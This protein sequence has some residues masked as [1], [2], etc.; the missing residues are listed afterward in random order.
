MGVLRFKIFRDIWHQKGRTLQVMLIIGIGA[1]AIGMILTTRNLVVPGM[2]SGWQDFR[3]PMVRIFVDPPVPESMMDELAHIKN[4][5]EIEGMNNATIEWRLKPTD[6]WKQGGLTARADYNDMVMDKLTLVEGDWPHDETVLIGQGDDGFFGLPKHGDVYLRYDDKVYVLHVDGV[7]YNEFQQPASFGGTAQFYV[8]KEYYDKIIGNLDYGQLL[9]RADFP[10]DEKKVGE[11]AD[12]IQDRLE[13]SNR[14]SGRF[15]TDPNKHF[16]QDSM[17]G[18]FFLLGVL[19]VVALIMGL[20]LVYNTINSVIISQVDQIGVMKAV[21]ARTS[22]IVRFFLLVVTIYGLLALFCSM[23]MTI[24]G[25]WQIS[26]WLI[27]SFGADPGSFQVDRQAVLV[28]CLIALIAP[29]LAALVP[30]WSASRTTVREAISTYGLG[31][32]SGL[33]EKLLAR[34]RYISRLFIVTVTNT[35]RHKGRVTLLQIALVISGLV[36]MTVI[37]VRDSVVY[38]VK[39][40][41]FSILNA[42]VTLAFEDPQRIA[43]IEAL[44]LAYPGVKSVEM[45]GLTG[46]TVRPRGQKSSEDDKEITL[47]GVPLPTQLYGYQLRAGRWLTPDDGYAMVLNTKLAEDAKVTIGDWVTV[48]YSE[49][50]ERDYQIV[51]L[52]FDP[53]LTTLGAVPRELLLQ[54]LG[55]VGRAPAVWLQTEQEGLP[56]E[57]DLAK[58]LRQYYKDNNIKVSAQRGVFG[59][60]GDSTTETAN[61]LINQFNFLIVLLAIMA[62]LIGAVGS[63]ALSGAISLSVLERRREIGVMRA[64]GASTWSI[65]RLFIGEGLIL[66]WLSWLISMPLSLYA[67]KLMVYALGQAFGLEIVYHYTPAGLIMWFAIITFLSIIASVL[68]ARGATHIS[69]RES[70]AYQ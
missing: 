57:A 17:D 14:E 49:K 33:L 37:S 58:G 24:L 11:L 22:Q 20:L 6:E 27:N 52:T 1:A 5:A 69:V 39:D 4:V 56:Y 23:P 64:I 42:N 55:Q 61:A 41:L 3:S 67:S 32:N 40:V 60:G 21:G 66:G 43:R 44:T 62:V 63:I 13:K 54:D 35:F 46:A 38:T 51:G 50:N 70:L 25:G 30:I 26:S 2:Q 59:F 8:D 7:L 45:W 18:L 34:A 28:T 47:F 68:P 10:F 19:G 15:V 65:F 16:F 36:F 31:T 53:I 9:V 48:K 12:R 29:M